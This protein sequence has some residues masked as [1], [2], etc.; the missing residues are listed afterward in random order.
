[1]NDD[2]TKT[3]DINTD[4]LD[5]FGDLLDGR[6][7]ENSG[8]SE[9]EE[10]S[11]EEVIEEE[12]EVEQET[13]ETE[14][15]DDNPDATE[16]E[17][18]EQE[19]VEE[20]PASK[21]KGNSFQERINELTAARREAER[22]EEAERNARLEAERR[23]REKEESSTNKQN[24]T[25]EQ[26]KSDESGA[27]KAPDPTDKEKYPLGEYDPAYMDDRMEYMLEQ[28]IAK[29]NKEDAARREQAEIEQRR[30]EL[31]TSWQ[32]KL[33]DASEKHEDFVE[34]TAELE[35]VF[36]GIDEQNGAFL[37]ETVMSM[38]NGADVLYYFANNRSE[39]EAL[40]AAGPVNAALMLGR[41]QA[42]LS[43][44][45]EGTRTEKKTVTKK[46]SAPTP[47]RNLNKGNSPRMSVP[48]DTDDLDAFEGVFFNE[49]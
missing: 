13:E 44:G 18:T 26:N 16:D 22:R 17:E 27:S 23:L 4:N 38:E 49:K 37:A 10:V 36:S 33:Q 43:D 2:N 28:R 34:K 6:A 40:A 12:S 1:M 14:S 30:N 48:V 31:E 32:G 25:E 11:S 46:S 29:L 9:T 8:N 19:E 21:K 45:N 47:P 5:D 15:V 24:K 41:V 42:S 20:K 39:A 7:V 35:S 3:V